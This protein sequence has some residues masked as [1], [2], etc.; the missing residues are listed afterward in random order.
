MTKCT[1]NMRYSKNLNHLVK[2]YLQRCGPSSASQAR[3]KILQWTG[4]PSRAF[5]PSTSPTWPDLFAGLEPS[6]RYSSWTWNTSLA[7]YCLPLPWTEKRNTLA[8]DW[9]HV[10]LNLKNADSLLQEATS[11]I[12]NIEHFVEQHQD[13]AFA[14]S[15]HFRFNNI[16]SIILYFK[17]TIF[18]YIDK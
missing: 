8:V 16:D 15:V 2:E 13:T 4:C 11:Q 10:R 18:F 7:L 5:L 6:S 1:L 3:S 17:S 12:S 14:T 9:L